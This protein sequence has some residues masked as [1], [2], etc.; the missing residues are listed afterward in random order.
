[1]G[2]G[3]GSGVLSQSAQGDDLRR[4]ERDPEIDHRKARAG[5]L[6]MDFDFS[7]EQSMLASS[8][9]RLVRERC[10]FETR[11]AQLKND[12]ATRPPLWKDLSELG[13]TALCV[14]EDAG[15]LG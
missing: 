4:I 11:R 13:V 15:G 7:E 3:T 2:A 9:E 1:M 8:C 12:P 5:A 10:S 14:P 6:K